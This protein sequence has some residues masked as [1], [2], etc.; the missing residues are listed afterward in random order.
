M[1]FSIGN[2]RWINQMDISDGL[3][4]QMERLDGYIKWKWLYQKEISE[5]VIKG[6]YQKERLDGRFKRKYQRE[7]SYGLIRWIYPL[8]LSHI[9]LISYPPYSPPFSLNVSFLFSF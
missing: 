8:N 7:I 4:Y 5:G 2:I 3:T 1:D 9:F 6:K